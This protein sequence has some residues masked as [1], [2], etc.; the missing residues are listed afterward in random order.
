MT[1]TSDVIIIHKGASLDINFDTRQ[2]EKEF[3]TE[4]L[5]VRRHGLR[6]AE[7]IKKRMQQL[8]AAEVLQHMR[9]LPQ[10][11]CHE[12]TADRAGQLS[13]DLDGPYRLIFVPADDP[14]PRKPDGG[15]DWNYVTAIVILGV[16]NTHE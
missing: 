10:A 1:L 6:R 15:L 9:L 4:K 7:L 2:L 12:L 13:V 3:N 8:R 16:E 5:L 11:R 14:L